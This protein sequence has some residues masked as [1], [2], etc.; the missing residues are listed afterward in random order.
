MGEIGI[1]PDRFRYGLRWWEILCI[2]RGYN[3][4]HRDLWSSTRWQTYNIMAS[5]VGGDKLSEKGINSPKDLLKL[6]WD[7]HHIPLSQSEVEDMQAEIR[8]MNAA[9]AGKPSQNF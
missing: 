1:S 4:R 7:N 9:N 3:R 8:A 6:P 2:I 5:F